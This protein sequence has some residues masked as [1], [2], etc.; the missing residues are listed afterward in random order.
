MPRK[1]VQASELAPD[2]FDLLEDG[3]LKLNYWSAHSEVLQFT[4]KLQQWKS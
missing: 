2:L 1:E 4:T 3:K